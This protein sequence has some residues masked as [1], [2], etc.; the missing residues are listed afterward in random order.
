[1]SGNKVYEGSKP[2]PGSLVIVPS[3][4]TWCRALIKKY[5]DADNVRVNIL[6]FVR[7]LSAIF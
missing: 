6:R 5:L 7:V 1:M 4:G 2:R 3:G